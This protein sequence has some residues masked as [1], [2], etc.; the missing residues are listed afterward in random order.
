MELT[1]ATGGMF[2]FEKVTIIRIPDASSHMVR[3]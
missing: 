1:F 2:R 3:I